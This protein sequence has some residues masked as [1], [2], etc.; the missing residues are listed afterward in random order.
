M[1]TVRTS[2]RI[3]HALRHDADV[4]RTADGWVKVSA[5]LHRPHI[6]RDELTAVLDASTRYELD[7]HGQPPR[8]RAGRSAESRCAAPCH[9]PA[10]FLPAVGAVPND[11]GMTDTRI[12]ALVLYH[13]ASSEYPPYPTKVAPTVELYNKVVGGC[14]E[15]VHLELPDG[16]RAMMYVNEEGRIHGLP[17]NPLATLVARQLNRQLG[18]QTILGNAI[19]VGGDGCNDAD[20]PGAVA[21]LASQLHTEFRIAGYVRRLR[22]EA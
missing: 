14:I 22:G 6:T 15:G 16:T 10:H 20:V 9:V 7:Q 1:S 5:L 17:P 8:T 21:S 3:A 2:R 4:Q 18:N 13:D 11:M 12:S 19:V